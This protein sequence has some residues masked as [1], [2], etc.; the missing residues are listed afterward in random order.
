MKEDIARLKGRAGEEAISSSKSQ[1]RESP[2]VAENMSDSGALNPLKDIVDKVLVLDF[3]F[4]VFA[5]IWLGVSLGMRTVAHS[6]VRMESAMVFEKV[7]ACWVS[8]QML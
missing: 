1:A 4:V 5:L 6:S 8:F 3:F 7:S 2:R